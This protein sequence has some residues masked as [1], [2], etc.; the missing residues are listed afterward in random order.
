MATSTIK[1]NGVD[2]PAIKFT[3]DNKEHYLTSLEDLVRFISNN[4]PEIKLMQVSAVPVKGE[5]YL[6]TVVFGGT[7][8][9]ITIT[10]SYDD[11]LFFGYCDD[12]ILPFNQLLE[13]TGIDCTYCE[14]N[15]K[16]SLI[17]FKD[18]STL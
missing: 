15:G 3:Y 8:S 13:V 11:D 12:D 5:S 9:Y 16:L 17:S 1:I 4:F 10:K 7:D 2:T 6:K 18:N 14:A